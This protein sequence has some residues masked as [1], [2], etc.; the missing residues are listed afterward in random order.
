[1]K[2]ILA[3]QSPRRREILSALGYTFDVVTL[4]TDE[5]LPADISPREA[6]RL[7]AERKGQAVAATLP[8]TVTVLSSDT[9]VELDGHALGKPRD[10]A[11]AWRMLLALS[12]RTHYVRTGVAVRRGENV[13]SGVASAA[14]TFR[15]I[16]P[17]EA[18]A[19]VRTGE[20]MDKAGAYGI[21]GAGGTFVRRLTGD[22]DTVMGL[23]GALCA[24]LLALSGVSAGEIHRPPAGGTEL[25][26][27]QDLPFLIK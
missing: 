23:S 6:V 25:A 3:S 16:T 19:Y 11:D 20:P 22:F 14:V 1:M 12:G 5:S 7:L 2:L 8:A 24:D 9:L 18:E 17:E 4:P 27:A 10:S 15:T 13:Y 21:Q 26:C